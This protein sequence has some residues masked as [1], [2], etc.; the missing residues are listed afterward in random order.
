MHKECGAPLDRMAA[1][2]L[3]TVVSVHKDYVV[4]DGGCKTFPTDPLLGQ[5]PY[6][7]ESYA[8][9]PEK[10]QLRLTKLT[11]E[12]GMV[13]ADRRKSRFESRRYP[14]G[15]PASYLSCGKFAEQIVYC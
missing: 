2:L 12:H 4:V 14:G 6:Y 5:P 13:T 1:K 10:P 9:F 8:Y 3:V 11:E 15:N 7:F